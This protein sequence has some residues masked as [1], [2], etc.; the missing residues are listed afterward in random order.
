MRIAK[1]ALLATIAAVALA[2]S[3]GLAAARSANPVLPM[4]TLT[5]KGPDGSI[6]KIS[7]SGNV[8]PIVHFEKAPAM[9]RAVAP[10]WP[11]ANVERISAVMNREMNV[12]MQQADMLSSPLFAM[13]PLY[14]AALLHPV[15][16]SGWPMLEQASTAPGMCMQSVEVSR[17]GDAAP[18]VVEHVSGNCSKGDLS[19]A[20]F[21]PRNGHGHLVPVAPTATRHAP[22][23][24]EV[25]YLPR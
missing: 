5:V 11:F 21:L 10:V 4:H 17:I 3:A 7:Y 1:S 16:P 15:G 12:L 23:V 6:A 9:T 2:T 24:R 8:T 19:A 14:N 25:R 20:A 22:R 18:H 13:G